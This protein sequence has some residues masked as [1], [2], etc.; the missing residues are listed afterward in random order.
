MGMELSLISLQSTS[1]YVDWDKYMRIQTIPKLI[2]H[3][4]QSNPNTYWF[5][6]AESNPILHVALS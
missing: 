6:L 1:T 3:R 5:V 2:K 4:T